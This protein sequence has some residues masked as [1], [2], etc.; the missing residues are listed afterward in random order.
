MSL[1]RF[2]FILL[3]IVFFLFVG[4]FVYDMSRKTTNPWEKK[5]KSVKKEIFN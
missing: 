1:K 2:L 3:S 5:N 4:Y